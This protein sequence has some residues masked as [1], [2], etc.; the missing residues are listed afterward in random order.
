MTFLR[1]LLTEMEGANINTPL[2]IRLMLRNIEAAKRL[3]REYGMELKDQ[4]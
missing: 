1:V 2:A 3:N 4:R